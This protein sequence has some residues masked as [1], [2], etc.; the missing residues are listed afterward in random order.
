MLLIGM[1]IIG[2]RIIGADACPQE[3]SGI[4]LCQGL[5]APE[6]CVEPFACIRRSRVSPT[7]CKGWPA[8]AAKRALLKARALAQARQQQEGP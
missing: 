3:P 6:C 8:S 1:R 2:M 5:D 4:G 7:P